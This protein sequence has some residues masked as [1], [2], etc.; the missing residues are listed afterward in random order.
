MNFIKANNSKGETIAQ[1]PVGSNSSSK[2]DMADA[3]LKLA[4]DRGLAQD[5]TVFLYPN[6]MPVNLLK[7][8]IKGTLAGFLAGF[9]NA[10]VQESKVTTW[11]KTSFG[12]AEIDFNSAEYWY[13][14]GYIPEKDPDG[15]YREAVEKLFT[16][17]EKLS[18][19][20]KNNGVIGKNSQLSVYFKGNYKGKKE[21]GL[22][23]SY[24]FDAD[25]QKRFKLTVKD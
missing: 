20:G 3:I 6:E 7:S 10:S 1:I 25:Y 22:A 24:P 19:A 18:T 21:E 9:P 5:I 16:E 11:I 15:K 8:E 13:L 2:S 14:R 23:H 17:V 4:M 12:G